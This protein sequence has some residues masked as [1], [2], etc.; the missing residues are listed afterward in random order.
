MKQK[1][2]IEKPKYKTLFEHIN[3]ITATQN[4]NYWDDLNDGDR[5][6]WSNYMVH[7][8][9]SMKPEWIGLVNDFQSLN[10]KPRE[11]Y[12]L[13]IDILPKK[14]QWL[15]YIGGKKVMKHEEWVVE[16]ITKYHEVSIKEANE[17][18]EIYYSTEQGK[19][20]LKSIL[21]KY[22]IEPKQIKKLKLP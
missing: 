14:K 17:Y 22:G 8:F 10:L 12:K 3:H 9:L 21:Q 13:Y 7:R 18:L 1:T 2:K 6:S 19:A 15:K 11:L 16:I 5:K 20:D 4:K